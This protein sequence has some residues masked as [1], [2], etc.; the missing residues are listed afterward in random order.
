MGAHPTAE[1][2]GSE[3]LHKGRDLRVL[4]SSQTSK[5][6]EEQV[7]AKCSVGSNAQHTSSKH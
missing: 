3:I 2:N 7:C 4:N 5:E 1:S 6:L